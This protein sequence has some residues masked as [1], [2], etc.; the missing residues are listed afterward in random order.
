MG[1]ENPICL[2]LLPDGDGD[3]IINSYSNV[4]PRLLNK[5]PTINYIILASKVLGFIGLKICSFG[6]FQTK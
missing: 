6:I 3:T 4:I 1:N 2:V 5:I